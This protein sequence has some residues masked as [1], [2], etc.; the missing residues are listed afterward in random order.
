MQKK[1]SIFIHFTRLFSGPIVVSLSPEV[2]AS[3]SDFIRVDIFLGNCEVPI[4]KG[5][6]KRVVEHTYLITFA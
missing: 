2:E 4:N 3:I 1:T 6:T 5:L